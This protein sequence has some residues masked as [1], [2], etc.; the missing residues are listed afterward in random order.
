M[1]IVLDLSAISICLNTQLAREG[2]LARGSV[3]PGGKQRV[4]GAC[5]STT[6]DCR[7]GRIGGAVVEGHPLG[8]GENGL[9]LPTHRRGRGLNERARTAHRGC[10]AAIAI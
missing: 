5:T 7:R 1:P 8:I 4:P 9:R 6:T 3:R 10:R 2:C